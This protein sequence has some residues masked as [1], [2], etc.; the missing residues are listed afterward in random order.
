[1][2]SPTELDSLAEAHGPFYPYPDQSSFKLGHWYWNSSVQKLHQSFKEL[3]DIVGQPDF[4]PDDVQCTHWDKIN[5]QLGAS[6]DNEGESE[7]EDEDAGWCKTP[8]VIKIPFS[9][10]TAQPGA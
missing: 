7:W 6:I 5:L 4:D 9:C 3:L 10:T 8:I 2:V 1:M